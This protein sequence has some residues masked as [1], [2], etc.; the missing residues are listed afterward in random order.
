MES[1]G[2]VAGSPQQC[3]RP[4]AA[5]RSDHGDRDPPPFEAP[6][7][8]CR[9]AHKSSTTAM[10]CA[11]LVANLHQ[12]THDGVSERPAEDTRCCRDINLPA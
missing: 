4:P 9:W 11:F 3:G 6:P 2:L 7:E 8:T 10:A 1:G 5:P 12:E